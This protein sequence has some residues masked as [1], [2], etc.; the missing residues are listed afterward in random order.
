MDI[1][2]IDYYSSL[3]VAI[4]NKHGSTDTGKIEDYYNYIERTYKSFDYRLY[5]YLDYNEKFEKINNNWICLAY[6]WIIEFCKNQLNND[7]LTPRTKNII[8]DYFDYIRA[9]PTT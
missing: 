4:E 3:L 2:L 9:C 1:C 8:W 6:D 7:N 5:V